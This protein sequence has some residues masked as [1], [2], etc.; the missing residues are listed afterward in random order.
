MSAL[1][2][3]G[4][5]AMKG[6]ALELMPHDQSFLDEYARCSAEA[7]GWDGSEPYRLISF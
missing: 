3:L 6:L 7:D 5:P 4:R 2:G 1:R